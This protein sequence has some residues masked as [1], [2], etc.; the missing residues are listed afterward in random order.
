MQLQPAASNYHL[1]MDKVRFGRALGKGARGA[2]RSLWEAADAATS[3]DPNPKPRTQ[4]SATPTPSAQ[5]ILGTVIDAHVQA[6]RVVAHTQQQAARAGAA[7]VRPVLANAKRLTSVLWLEVTGS[8]FAIFALSLGIAVWK[9]RH[10]FAAGWN[11]E[12]AHKLVVYLLAFAA[13][14]YFAVSS[15]LRAKRR[16]R[17]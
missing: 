2:A 17:Q 10:A 6:H 7:A 1:S 9:N 16:E 8:F 12:P 11:T 3:P 5:E 15:F 14:A 13:F 4:A